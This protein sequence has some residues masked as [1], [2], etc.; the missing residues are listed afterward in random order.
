MFGDLK[1]HGFDLER[2]HLLDTDKFSRLTL[3]VVLLFVWLLCFGVKVTKRG[4]RAFVERNDRR[5]LSFFQI[6]LR[7]LNRLLRNHERL[8]L[9]SL[10]PCR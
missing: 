8:P 4:L 1:G 3:A 6:G 5:D 2:T 10:L 9:V 7:Y